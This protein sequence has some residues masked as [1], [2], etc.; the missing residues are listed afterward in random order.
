[1]Q[2]ADIGDAIDD[3]LA[4]QLEQQPQD[5]VRGGVLRTHVEQHGLARHGAL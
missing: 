2:E 4:I 5:P 3:H 1:M